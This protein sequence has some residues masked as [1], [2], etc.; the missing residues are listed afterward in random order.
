M[1][2]YKGFTL[3]LTIIGNVLED[4]SLS[5]T[6]N[7]TS[8]PTN[9]KLQKGWFP[10]GN[11]VSG[12]PAPI[13]KN[14]PR[15]QIPMHHAGG[16]DILQSSKDLMCDQGLV[17]FSEA[18]APGGVPWL[19]GDPQKNSG[20]RPIDGNEHGEGGDRT[21]GEHVQEKEPRGG[22]DSEKLF[23][24]S[25]ALFLGRKPKNLVCLFFETSQN[26]P[27]VSFVPK[28]IPNTDPPIGPLAEGEQWK[29]QRF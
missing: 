6:G 24:Q 12:L 21:A 19:S 29:A 10:T 5:T 1:W 26:S 3:L 7:S 20:N 13:Q 22:K 14:V 18:V 27:E 2:H 4:F 17:H 9:R 11:S 23:P 25:E 15:L 28:S 16:M 8:S